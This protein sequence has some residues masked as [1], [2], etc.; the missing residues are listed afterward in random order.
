MPTYV[1]QREDGSTFEQV[2][3][4]KAEPLKVCPETGQPVKRVIQPVAT[5][6]KGSGW[7]VTDY[8]GK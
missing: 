2:Q 6:Y 7:Y 1:Y 4:I 3:K 8:K 5:H